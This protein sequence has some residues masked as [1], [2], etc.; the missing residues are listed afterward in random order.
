MNISPNNR[1]LF[2]AASQ[3]KRDLNFKFLWTKNGSVF[4]RKNDA[5]EVIEISDDEVISQLRDSVN[6][7]IHSPAR[8]EE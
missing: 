6:N 8:P 1:R 3:I 2:T 5:T 4:L 7:N